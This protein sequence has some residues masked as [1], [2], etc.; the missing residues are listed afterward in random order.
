MG[1]YMADQQTV[2][3]YIRGKFEYWYQQSGK[4]ERYVDSRHKSGL[5]AEFQKDAS[6]INVLVCPYI[7]EA[8]YYQSRSLIVGAADGLAGIFFGFPIHSTADVIL[9]ALMDVCGYKRQGNR[10]LEKSI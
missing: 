10:L 4:L 5:V 9:G 6:G 3:N 1:S 2:Y 7:K 8:G